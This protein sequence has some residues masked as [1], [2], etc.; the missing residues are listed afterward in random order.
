V[1]RI[2]AAL[3][4]IG[5]GVFGLLRKEAWLPF[6]ALVGLGPEAAH[7]LM[8]LIGAIDI[9]MGI[10]AIV[11]PR[12]I[13]F[14][15]MAVWAIWTGALRP[16]TGDSLAELTERAGNYGVP[17]ALLLM[18]A[19][20]ASLRAWLA[21][22]HTT[23]LPEIDH[24]RL[25]RLLLAVTV[26][27]LAGHGFIG[28]NGSVLLAGHYES[29][30]L[31]GSLV[32]TIGAME[33][34]A[35][36]ALALRPGVVL[37]L[38]ICAWKLATESLFLV[39]GAPVW[40]F[41]ERGGS[42]VAPL[43]LA[44][45]LVAQRRNVP[46]VRQA[47]AM[48]VV[49][50]AA[51]AGARAAGAQE[52][53]VPSERELLAELRRG[54][55]VLACRHGITDH[56]ARDSNGSDY[57]NRAAQRNLTPEGEAQSRRMGEAIAALKLPFGEIFTSPMART[58]E[59][60]EMMFGRATVNM[61][62]RMTPDSAALRRLFTDPPERGVIRVLMTHTGVLMRHFKGTPLRQV[63]EGGCVLV[64]PDGSDKPRPWALI[65]ER[66]WEAMRRV[67]Q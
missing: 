63:P 3:C 23:E 35:A 65:T 5:H 30:G 32:S 17:M 26:L 38:A 29:I 19:P 42:Y 31:A 22:V 34:S 11:S 49:L 24:A 47:A 37:A 39:A 53:S 33:I 6:F 28:I 59:S 46:L 45:V 60:A 50:I 4:F 48:A 62:L 14:A 54:G 36:L 61:L 44:M 67:A 57:A 25:G 55:V 40:E 58:K 52:P 2:G 51:L 7:Y 21:R 56:D 43:A 66:E 15:Y 1:L 16:L 64:R 18:A 10:L 20:R 12:P 41:V 27:L 9:A 13:V 8:P